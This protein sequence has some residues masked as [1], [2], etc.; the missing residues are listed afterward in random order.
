[1]RRRIISACMGAAVA[2]VVFAGLALA[3][4]VLKTSGKAKV[5]SYANRITVPLTAP[6]QSTVQVP[7][8]WKCP[9][10]RS[11]R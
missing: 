4:G 9:T 2:L 11:S 1:M 3:T 10:S 6:Q 5:T 7:R 8:C